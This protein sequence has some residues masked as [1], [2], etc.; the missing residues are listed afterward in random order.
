VN[1]D[2]KSHVTVGALKI[3]R[4]P[5]DQGNRAGHPGEAF[6]LPVE[7]HSEDVGKNNLCR[8]AAG[9]CKAEESGKIKEYVAAENVSVIQFTQSNNEL[10][11]E[12]A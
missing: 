8:K 11:Y 7:R 2:Q 12:S 6:H 5:E 10:D 9:S 3:C 1:G 4:G